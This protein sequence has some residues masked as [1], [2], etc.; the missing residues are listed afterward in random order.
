M[1]LNVGD[2]VL[3]EFYFTNMKATK[4]RPVLVFKNNLPYDDFISIP[5]SSQVANL[6]K[7]EFLIDNGSLKQGNIPKKSKYML[8]KTFFVSKDIVI[9]KYG[10]LSSQEFI[11]LKQRFCTYFKCNN[12]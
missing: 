4:K 12:L 6:K 1:E 8:R 10:A 9:K 2:I 5:I 3:C 11:L 7:D